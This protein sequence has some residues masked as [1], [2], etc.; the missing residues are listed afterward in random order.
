MLTEHIAALRALAEALPPGSI[1]SIPRDW[2]LELLAAGPH[3][4]VATPAD[5]T[6]EAI[7]AH[8]GRRPSTIR[9]W[10][11]AGRFPGAYKLQGREWRIPRAAVESFEA[12]ERPAGT[13]ARGVQSLS[14]WR[15]S[16]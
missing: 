4:V 16:S 11:E 3:S 6:V 12:A 15:R 5:A 9:G 13:K 2:V 8:Y 14:D 10:C 7:G 1:M